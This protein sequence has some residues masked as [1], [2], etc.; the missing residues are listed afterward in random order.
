MMLGWGPRQEPEKRDPVSLEAVPAAV[1]RSIE[2]HAPGMTMA[3]AW[4]VTENGE[5]FYL[6]NGHAKDGDKVEFQ[7]VESGRVVDIRHD[8][9]PDRVPADVVDQVKALV[10]NAQIVMADRHMAVR[11]RVTVKDG[12]R[13][14]AV[15]L[16]ADG[17][18][19]VL[20]EESKPPKSHDAKSTN[21]PTGR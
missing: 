20:D 19:A 18:H 7:T 3:H 9:P 8:F 6:V 17:K 16:R 2:T 13:T 4:K 10:P 1:K 21:P 5:M 12:E 15:I 14:R 11:W